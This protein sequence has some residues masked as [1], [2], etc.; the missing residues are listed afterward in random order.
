MRTQL[1]DS[2]EEAVQSNQRFKGKK[3]ESKCYL[4]KKL[5]SNSKNKEFQL[6]GKHL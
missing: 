5:S 6:Q 2:V 4:E 3:A 1:C